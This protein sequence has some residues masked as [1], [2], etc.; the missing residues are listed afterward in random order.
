MAYFIWTGTIL[1]IFDAP[2]GTSKIGMRCVTQK[3][4]I[5]CP[6]FRSDSCFK[7]SCLRSNL[8][9]LPSTAV[10]S[11]YTTAGVMRLK[12]MTTAHWSAQMLFLLAAGDPPPADD[13]ERQ[14]SLIQQW[15]L[16]YEF[17]SIFILFEEHQILILC[18]YS[19]ARI[20]SQF[21]GSSGGVPVRILQTAKRGEP[22]SGAI[23]RFFAVYASKK[24]VG[25]LREVHRGSLIDEWLML[26]NNTTQTP[27]LV[28]MGP[29]FS[30]LMATDGLED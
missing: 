7:R 21:E 29:A 6:E 25:I 4:Y 3:M 9:K 10:Y 19:K 15:L 8:T 30:A 11:G 13:P 28:N 18:S 20:L 17:A 24:R 27:K 14:G 1:V 2:A 5:Q 26:L 22:D 16:G 23:P 12:I